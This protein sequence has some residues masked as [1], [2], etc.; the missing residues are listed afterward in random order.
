[1]MKKGRHR[2]YYIS[3]KKSELASKSDTIGV[4]NLV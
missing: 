2:Q 1:V 3:D 4:K